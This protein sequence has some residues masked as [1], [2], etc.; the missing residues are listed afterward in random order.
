L[1]ELEAIAQRIKLLNPK[2]VHIFFNNNHDMLHNAREMKELL[3]EHAT[4]I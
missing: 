4:Y 2:N 3:A 1:N